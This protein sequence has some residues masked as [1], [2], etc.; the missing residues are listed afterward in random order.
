MDAPLVIRFTPDRKD[1]ILA[2]RM[3]ATNSTGFMIMAGLILLAMIAAAVVLIF[4]AV[5]TAVWRN[6]AFVVLLVG[7]FYIVYFLAIIPWQ[8]SRTYKSNEYLQKARTLTFSESGVTM[9]VG[10]NTSNLLWENFKHVINGSGFYLLVYVGEN[11]VYPFIP[12]RAFTA[13]ASEEAF[14]ALLEEKDI[15]LR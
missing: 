5:G 9:A 15:P 10:G 1:Y 12:K 14:L 7:A 13:E 3:L 8:L 6:T 11:R 2:S 4:P